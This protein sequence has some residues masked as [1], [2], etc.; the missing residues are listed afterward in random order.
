MRFR[1]SATFGNPPQAQMYKEL[2]P[3]KEEQL[4]LDNAVIWI[5][6]SRVESGTLESRAKFC[7]STFVIKFLPPLAGN[8]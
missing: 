8:F 6:D 1:T 2:T 3:M 4:D 7:S 5:P